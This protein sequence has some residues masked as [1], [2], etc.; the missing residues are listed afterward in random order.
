M[1][2]ATSKK[3]NNRADPLSKKGKK[4]ASKKEAK[5]AET[6]KDPKSSHLCECASSHIQVGLELSLPYAGTKHTYHLEKAYTCIPS[7]QFL[8]PHPTD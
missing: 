4:D 1:A 2:K 5:E 6:S 8:V 3:Q 7:S